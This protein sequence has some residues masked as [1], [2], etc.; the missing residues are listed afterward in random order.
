[1]SALP[2]RAVAFSVTASKEQMSVALCET[3]AVPPPRS[4]QYL[5]FPEKILSECYRVLKPGGCVIFS[6]SNRMFYQ[7]AIAVRASACEGAN[8]CARSAG[9]GLCAAEE[10]CLSCEMVLTCATALWHARRR[11]ETGRVTLARSS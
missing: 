7:K 4:V 9:K 6:F 10:D 8:L 2:P 1:M 3:L 5:Q 11:G